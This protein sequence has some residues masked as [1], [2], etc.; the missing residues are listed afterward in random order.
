MGGWTSIRDAF[1]ALSS[2]RR[3]ERLAQAFPHRTGKDSFP[4]TDL[5]SYFHAN[6]TGPGIWK[7]EHYFEVYERHLSKFRGHAPVVVEIG[8]YSGGSLGMWQ[9][10]FGPDARVVGVDIEPACKVYERDGIDIVI[11]DQASR[12]FWDEFR[13]RFPKVDI[14]IDDGGHLPEQQSV[15]LEEMLPHLALGGVYLCEDIHGRKNAFMQLVSG[16][17]DC[18]NDKARPTKVQRAVK[19]ISLY[20]FVAVIELREEPLNAL[21]APR[22]GSEWQPFLG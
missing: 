16:F 5:W 10:Y 13:R 12:S 7:W 4:E 11:G 20:P 9:S 18:L 15:T 17:A 22:R 21:S 6:T 1:R 14:L 8:V 2:C 19:G 3:G